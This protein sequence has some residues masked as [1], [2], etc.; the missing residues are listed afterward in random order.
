VRV[1]NPHL[2]KAT[3]LDVGGYKMAEVSVQRDD[4]GLSVELPADTMYLVL[5]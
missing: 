3:L 2:S 5:E 4:R 1:K